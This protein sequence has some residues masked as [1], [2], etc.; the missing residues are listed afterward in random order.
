MFPNQFVNVT[1][2]VDTL[3]RQVIVPSTAIRHGPQGDFVYVLQPD[4]TVKVRQVKS[5]P[6]TGESTSIA[7]GL[8]AGETVIT[9]GGDRLRDGAPVTLPKP[10]GAG[11]SNSAAGAAAAGVFGGV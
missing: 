7:S 2:L 11:A 5:G 9:E 8:A 1:V 10:R 3:K 4:S 6:S